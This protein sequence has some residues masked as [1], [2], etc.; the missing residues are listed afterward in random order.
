M[1]AGDHKTHILSTRE[2]NWSPSLKKCLLS[3]YCIWVLGT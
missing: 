3:S 2:G 1:V